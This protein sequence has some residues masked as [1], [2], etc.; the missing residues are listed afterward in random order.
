MKQS[1]LFTKTRWE[2]PSDETAKN[3]KLLIRAGFIH[4]ELAGVYDYLPLGLRV[5]RKIEHIIRTEMNKIGA[6]EVLLSSL[7]NPDIWQKSDRWSEDKVDNWFK[8]RLASGGE[9]GLANT[10]E[11]P[12]TA[13]LVHHLNSH[14]DLPQY[15]YQFQTKFRNEL[16]AKSGIMRTREF[17]MKDLYS[18]SKTEAEFREFY[19]K[20]ATAYLNIFDQVGLGEITYRT[21]ASGGAF[22]K[23]L[24]DEFQTLSEAGEDVIYVDKV[25]KIAVNKEVYNDDTLQ[26]L[27]LKRQ[28]LVEEKAIEVGNIF[29]LGTKYSDS[30]G[31]N[32]RDEAGLLH[33]VV[34]GS[35]GIGL[36]RLLGTIV[37]VLADEGGIV[38]PRTVAPFMVH[39]VALG[40]KEEVLQQATKLYQNLNKHNIEVLFDDRNM[41]AGEKLAD[42]DLLGMPLRV[43][44]SDKTITA[45]ILEVKTRQTGKVQ[46]LTEEE[47]IKLCQ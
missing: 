5:L 15:I 31:L 14:K 22:T 12:L 33:P 36:G 2:D 7:Q 32:F 46:T 21:A 3:A 27:G 24:T 11:E 28:D 39:I 17:L 44:I 42:A 40:S 19:E 47:L 18:F 4:K 10:H 43:V 1:Q 34:M 20:C 45:G 13:L 35:Y 38:W 37:E 29:P 30:L 23:V 16:R 8:T 9:V 6:E 41:S 26:V 25:K